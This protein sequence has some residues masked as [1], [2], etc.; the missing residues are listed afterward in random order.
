MKEFSMKKI[1]L[2]FCFV[3]ILAALPMS[4]FGQL[5]VWSFTDELDEIVNKYY[6]RSH[7]GVSVD[8]SRT[9][10]DMFQDKLDPVLASGQGVPDIIALE[11]AFVRKYVESGLLLDITDIYE[12]NKR[13]LLSY[14]VEIGTY[15][16]KVYALSW[17]ACPGAMFYR[18]SLA[19]K[20]L[21]TDDPKTVQ[22]YFNNFN[23]FLDTA[24]LL[25]DRSKSKC[26]VVSSL[27]ELIH[28]FLS[29]R[30]TP[31]VVNGKLVIDPIMDRSMDICKTLYD[32][33]LVAGVTQWSEGWFAG[34]KDDLKNESWEPLEVFSYFM[35]T[36][37][38]H[39]VLKT[40]AP[41]TSGDWAMIQ[42]PSPYHWG[43]TWIGAYKGT[44][45][46]AAVKE[47]I[48]YVTTDDAFL[49]AWAKDTG[50]MV[51]NINVIN[52]IKNNYS[53][54]YLGGQN[55]YA[56][57]GETAKIVN[58][59]LSQETDEMIE[60]LWDEEI[61]DYIMGEKTK[62]RALA[63]FRKEVEAELDSI[64]KEK[65]KA[66]ANSAGASKSDSAAS[67]G[68]AK[69][70]AQFK[71]WSF[72]DE[73][74]DIVNKYYKK[75]RS[76]VEI[77]YSQTPSDQF[78][79]RI[80]PLLASGQGA[81]DIISL[82]SSFVRKYVESGLLLDITDI[83]E[84]N[85]NKLIAYPAEVGTYKGRVYA[86]SWQACP[87]AMFYRRSLAKKYLGTDDPKTVQTY[88]NS[89]NKL[90]ETALLLKQKSNGVCVVVSSLGD[91][92]H[93]FLSARKNPWV[94][95]GKLDIDPV[96]DQYM[97]IGK[98]LRD[99]KFEG[100]VG[101][102]SEG[103]F[104]GM[105]GE[106]RDD[107]GRLLEVFSYFMP[108]WGLHYVLK[109]NAP[110]TSGDWAMIQGP[111]PYYWGGTWIG[112]FKGTKN[113]AA[114][115]EFI[116]YATTDE[117]FLEAWAKDTDD[118]IGSINVIN[119][120]KDKYAEKY[121]GGQ[122]AYSEF[123]ETAKKVNGKLIQGTDEMIGAIFDEAFYAFINKEKTKAQALSDFRRQV[124]SQLPRW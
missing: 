118:L 4:V 25:K 66:K 116:R 86:M 20:Y 92:R 70:T 21:G 100:G 84:A 35:P 114:V 50:D 29:A 42:G 7:S 108:T 23:K 81:P 16:G 88:F 89:F 119:K 15:N 85:K 115:K 124:E 64:R 120:I 79:S 109:T 96:M 68:S 55:Q 101:Q 78:Q 12:A 27:D 31:W 83:Y 110:G 123:A 2:F 122:N 44:K 90:L 10:S 32:N 67:G 41:S 111:S 98:T 107:N 117:A 24:K 37:G 112:A 69:T 94:V 76:G 53:E 91:L 3:F 72:T 65:E 49:E 56:D 22:T 9:S 36:W 104:A 105:K 6:K 11:S 26:V 59:K 46:V 75:S 39:Y 18:R 43:G 40:N 8:Y 99:N 33:D 106:L 58:G 60:E 54:P 62:A 103:W 71:V 87:G 17:Q 95:N 1:N 77:E 48:R 63:D 52:K 14:P 34:M 102:W 121:L 61:S 47:F 73:L 5:K 57:F 97:D 80:D 13:K 51:S 82:E 113:A 93:S 38:L 74:R 30:K 45:N 19:K 28:S